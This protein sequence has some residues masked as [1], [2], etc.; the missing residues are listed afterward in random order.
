MQSLA[1]KEICPLQLSWEVVT[2]RC[3]KA[4]FRSTKFPISLQTYAI[5]REGSFHLCYSLSWMQIHKTNYVTWK[6]VQHKEQAVSHQGGHT[7]THTACHQPP[8]MANHR[9]TSHEAVLVIRRGRCGGVVVPD[10]TPGASPLT[11]LA[12]SPRRCHTHQGPASSPPRP[13]TLHR[14]AYLRQAAHTP[15]SH[16]EYAGSPDGPRQSTWVAEEE[17]WYE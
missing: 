15:R 3:L 2:L 11:S 9:H 16:A 7:H 8:G 17:S 13:L 6:Q 12:L 14:Q 10:K 1:V 4:V 5:Q